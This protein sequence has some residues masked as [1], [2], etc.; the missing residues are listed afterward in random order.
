ME[1]KPQVKYNNL[2]HNFL[3][4]MKYVK[5]LPGKTSYVQQKMEEDAEFQT[6]LEK[7]FLNFL[8]NS[9]VNK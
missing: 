8:K 3:I 7:R 5:Y 2:G 6:E 9:F 1:K 4:K